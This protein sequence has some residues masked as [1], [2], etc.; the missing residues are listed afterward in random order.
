[1]DTLITYLPWLLLAALTIAFWRSRV[2]WAREL[3]EM[4][5]LADTDIETGFGEAYGDDAPAFAKLPP[6][7][8]NALLDEVTKPTHFDKF[9]ERDPATAGSSKTVRFRRYNTLGDYISGV[10][11]D[12]KSI[13]FDTATAVPG[14]EVVE[15]Q[16][17]P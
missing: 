5:L 3:E 8:A 11:R 15:V 10:Q 2:K 1:M 16:E 14:I 17:R 13:D 4:R 12:E 9:L 6:H 7:W